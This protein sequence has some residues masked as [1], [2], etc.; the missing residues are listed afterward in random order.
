VSL[1]LVPEA[2]EGDWVLVHAG[3]AISTLDESE[4]LKTWQYLKDAGLA[5]G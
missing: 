2:G 5:D 1:T 4:A 3:Y